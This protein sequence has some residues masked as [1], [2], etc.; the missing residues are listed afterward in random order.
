M[1][2]GCLTVWVQF[3]ATTSPLFL[4]IDV[5]TGSARAGIFTADGRM[6]ASASRAI[7]MWKPKPDFVEQ[8]SDDIWSACCDATREA[9]SKA[10][11]SP[12]RV[13]GIGFDAT[14]SLVALDA[15]DKPV[16]LSPDGADEQNVIV[17]MDHRAIGQAGRINKLK[18]PVLRYV[19]GVI[20]PEMQTPKLLWV[21]E[22]LPA[23]WTRTAHFFDL[24]D[25]LTYRATGDETRSLC[26]LV[27]K[28]TYLGH[29][30]PDGAGWDKSY[31]TKIGLSDLAKEG[32]VR[33]GTRVR[34]M[35]ESI[36]SGLTAR[37]AK[38]LGL[39]SGTAV[40]VSIID[41]HAGG[42][43]LLG[44]PLGKGKVTA[45]ALGKRL[46]LIGGTSSCHMAVSPEPRYINGVWGPYHSAMIPGL[47]LTEGGQSATGALIDHVIHSHAASGQ[48]LKEAKKQG[49]TI[50]ELL[51]DRLDALAKSE[52]VAHPCELTRSLHVSPDFHGNRSPRA[53]PTL[54][55]VISGLS[56]SAGADDLARLYL[57]TI[58]A[59][60]HGTRHIVHTLNKKGYAIRT[61]F[62][63]GGGTKNPVFL[64]EHA[65]I[66][67][68]ELILPREPEAV[69]LGSAVLGSVA[70]GTHASVVAAMAAMNAAGL[71]IK[72]TGGKVA[73]FHDSKH[74]VF[75]QMHK[76]HVRLR[77]LID[78]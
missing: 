51:N 48:L 71:A 49:R 78:A 31:F 13:K 17:W 21:K 29:R 4:G 22:N 12:D 68:C 46:A 66:T 9:L 33:I 63:C 3:M 52:A 40:G 39:V 62:V 59:V 11:V 36:G 19:G 16:S 72:P 67:G 6:L 26:S 18:H 74:R 53:D 73:A 32:F 69:L 65:D 20:S 7:R 15:N 76:D 23:A 27:C 75:L 35:G 58:Q 37:A 60:A 41:A 43:G 2:G 56:L 25:F 38:E 77:G 70:S 47:W 28:W 44:A 55:G 64:R 1:A 5:G 8:S 45:S 57:A 10:K 34:P 61:L 42:L 14:C 54:R 30:G 24:P 50:Y